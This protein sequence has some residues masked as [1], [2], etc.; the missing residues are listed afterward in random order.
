[1]ELG[2]GVADISGVFS[3]GHN[4]LGIDCN[5]QCIVE[6]GR[7]WKW[8]KVLVGD[9]TEAPAVDSDILILCE[10]LEHLADPMAVVER[11]MPKAKYCFLSS[12]LD[13]DR[14]A[15]HSGGEHSWSFEE[16]DFHDFFERGN[17]ELLLTEKFQMGPYTLFMALGKLKG[18]QA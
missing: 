17:H 6:A 5:A 3:W 8:M 4:V 7:A 11:W 9:I 10:V 14:G 12:P 13:G 1:V 18:E 16:K 15:D 2:C